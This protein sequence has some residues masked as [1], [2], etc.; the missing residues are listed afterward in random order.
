M[1]I[2]GV[3][4]LSDNISVVSVVGRYLEHARI[5]YFANGG[6]AETYLSSADW[7]PRNLERRI[8]LM[9]PVLDESLRGRVHEILSAYFKDNVKAHRLG[10]SGRWKRVE[11][12]EGE[13][14]FAS[15]EYFY[16]AMK[17]RRELEEEPPER[18]L[19]V[20]RKPPAGF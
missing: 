12:V 15:Q 16:E 7:M 9:F 17:R 6:S 8:E 2:P 5:L 3:K 4:G 20:R 14:R 13:A 1:L 19:Q 18:E 10:P 11:P